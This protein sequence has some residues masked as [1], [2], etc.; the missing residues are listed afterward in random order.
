M[1]KTGNLLEKK[2][3]FWTNFSGGL[4]LFSHFED[5]E[6]K[7][8]NRNIFHI[9]FIL[10]VWFHTLKYIFLQFFSFIFIIYFVFLVRKIGPELTFVANLPLFA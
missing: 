9:A 10:R 4:R 1:P 2:N 6:K 3:I 5:A 7:V 8:L